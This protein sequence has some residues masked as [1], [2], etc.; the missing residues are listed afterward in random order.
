MQHRTSGTAAVLLI[1]AG[2]VVLSAQFACDSDSDEEPA[3]AARGV[4]PAA[5][6]PPTPQPDNAQDEA[7]DDDE[8]AGSWWSLSEHADEL[9]GAKDLAAAFSETPQCFVHDE[10]WV[11]CTGRMSRKTEDGRKKRGRLIRAL[12]VGDDRRMYLVRATGHVDGYFTRFSFEDPSYDQPSLTMEYIDSQKRAEFLNAS[13]TCGEQKFELQPATQAASRKLLD[14]VEL[15]WPEP[16][17]WFWVWQ[18]EEGEMV[19]SV[20]TSVAG[21]GRHK[22]VYAG[23]PP[24][25]DRFDVGSQRMLRDGGTRTY[26]LGDGGALH[27]PAA[28][29]WRSFDDGPPSEEDMIEEQPTSDG[30]PMRRR[31][32]WPTFQRPGEDS[33][34]Q[35]YLAGEAASKE[36][37]ELT[38]PRPP[39][40]P[41]Y[42][43]I[44]GA[45]SILLD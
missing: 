11:V 16:P 27:L 7:V 42:P 5:P 21:V 13:L 22:A 17:R 35:L 38:V 37:L 23:E 9:P 34:H 28:Q 33:V 12:L 32:K 36:V 3:A 44:P 24:R 45:C 8:P 20:T 1:V 4:E 26:Y 6:S 15:Y 2:A 10:Q 39:R 19:I 25:L 30:E 29:L 31:L 41:P 43:E 18:T 14:S 40:K